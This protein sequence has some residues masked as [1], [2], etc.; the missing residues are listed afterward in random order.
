L[1][2]AES[3]LKSLTAIR[4]VTDRNARGVEDTRR[5]TDGLREGT[6]ALAALAT[7]LGRTPPATRRRPG[8]RK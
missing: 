3:I 5:A 6:A 1:L 7:R 4:A 8:G 2:A